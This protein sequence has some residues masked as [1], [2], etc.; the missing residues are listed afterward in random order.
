MTDELTKRFVT[1][2]G[3]AGCFNIQD[4]TKDRCDDCH[5]R[6]LSERELILAKAD[7]RALST[8]ARQ[9]LNGITKAS[10]GEAQSP[11]FLEGAL[12]KLGGATR[13]GEICADQFTKCRGVDP[14]TNQL[15]PEIEHP[16]LAVKWGELIARMMA[17]NDERESVDVG[18][19]TDDDLISTLQ[20]LSL[21]LVASSEDYCIATL[22]LILSKRPELLD[23]AMNS[24]GKPVVDGETVK[25]VV[26]A[27][28]IDLSE[29]GLDEKDSSED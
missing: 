9:I 5:E 4:T 27:P 28:K 11:A 3:C 24:A 14:E 25:P 16:A 13:F 19:L 10:K 26:S 7:E 15:A 6:F 12:S 21:D 23:R 2:L 17:R 18:S 8:A 20:A 22:E 29:I 1:C